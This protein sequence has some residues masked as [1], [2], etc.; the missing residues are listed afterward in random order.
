MSQICIGGKKKSPYNNGK[1]LQ[2][3]VVEALKA[4]WSAFVLNVEHLFNS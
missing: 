2:M 4:K 1:Y 3:M